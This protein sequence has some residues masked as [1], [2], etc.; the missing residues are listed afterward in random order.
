MARSEGRLE[1]SDSKNN[2]PHI[3]ITNNPSCARFA[4][5]RKTGLLVTD[6]KKIAWH[7]F[8]TFFFIDLIASFPF[9]LVLDNSA[10]TL[11]KGGK[12]MR[13][14]RLIKFLRLMRLLKL[15]R[16]IRLRQFVSRFEHDFS[17]HHGISRMVKIIFVVFLVTHLVGC[18]WFMIG[19][20]GGEGEIDGGWQWRYQMPNHSL[21]VR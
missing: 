3:H 13:L 1:R 9:G 16:V 5:R 2:I 7:Y 18:L 11:N 20:T 12:V 21:E 15:V 8:R 10:K 17:I 6:T 14:P 19:R 4:H